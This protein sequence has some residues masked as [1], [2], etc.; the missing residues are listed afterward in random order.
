MM[1]MCLQYFEKC[2]TL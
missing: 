1:H 2:L